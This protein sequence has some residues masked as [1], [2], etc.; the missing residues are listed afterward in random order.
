MGNRGGR[1]L[2]LATSETETEADVMDISKKSYQA[3]RQTDTDEEDRP[4]TAAELSTFQPEDG[5]DRLE[6]GP[7][8][9]KP[10]SPPP[11]LCFQNNETLSYPLY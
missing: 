11:S 5:R 3:D 4:P 9:T 1:E 6:N 8:Q 10:I 2:P 7:M